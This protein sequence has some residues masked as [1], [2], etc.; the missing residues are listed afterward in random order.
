MDRSNHDQT[1]ID[2][3]T[4]IGNSIQ[5]DEKFPW[6]GIWDRWTQAQADPGASYF[7]TSFT[8]Y[9]FQSSFVDL[10]KIFDV[11]HIRSLYAFHGAFYVNG[12]HKI[13]MLSDKACAIIS[14]RCFV[15]GLNEIVWVKMNI[16]HPSL[17]LVPHHDALHA[18]S[19]SYPVPYHPHDHCRVPLSGWR[20]R[21]QWARFQFG[22]VLRWSLRLLWTCCQECGAYVLK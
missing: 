16:L 20:Q 15:I 2:Q 8:N 10:G 11:Q 14:S 22:R 3:A 12:T 21:Y 6:N 1:W 19:S 5:I 17:A 13:S 9:R 7:W 18:H 4:K